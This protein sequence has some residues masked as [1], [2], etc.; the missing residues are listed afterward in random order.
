MRRAR[1]SG[2][3]LQ[4]LKVK[5]QVE[6]ERGTLKIQRNLKVIGLMRRYTP[7]KPGM[8]ISKSISSLSPVRENSKNLKNLEKTDL[9]EKWRKNPEGTLQG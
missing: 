7:G 1:A 3:L 4:I 5:K 6:I 9:V 2:N 8:A